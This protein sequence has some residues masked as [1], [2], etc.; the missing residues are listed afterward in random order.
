[1]FP[2]RF[3][4]IALHR[5]SWLG[6]GRSTSCVLVSAAIERMVIFQNDN[7]SNLPYRH[8]VVKINFA[9]DEDVRELF[10]EIAEILLKKERWSE[11]VS[12]KAV[13]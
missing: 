11:Q 7:D 6:A 10:D 8:S 3:P 2:R 9:Y 12:E 5:A 4:R 13:N 1:M